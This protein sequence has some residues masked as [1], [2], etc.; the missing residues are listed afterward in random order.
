MGK[1]TSDTIDRATR[2]ASGSFS[3]AGIGDWVL[4]RDSFAVSLAGTFQGSFEL[5]CSYDAGATAVPVTSA[6]Q[7][8][9]FTAPCREIVDEPEPGMLYRWRCVSLTSGE[10]DWRI[11]R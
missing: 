8:V 4:M 11:S 7:P 10:A 5:E 3:A 6:G 1:P 9:T 2:V